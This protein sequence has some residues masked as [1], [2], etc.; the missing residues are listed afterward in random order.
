M[1][2]MLA[3]AT[4]GAVAVFMSGCEWSG[5]GSDDGWSS[6]GISS[7]VSGVY[8]AA[9]GS[10][11][12]KKSAPSGPAG[13]E[14]ASESLGT[15]NGVNATFTKTLDNAPVTRGSV[16]VSDGIESF[17]DP[18]GDGS[19]T[20]TSGGNGTINYSSGQI[21]VNFFVSPGNG[22]SV[23]VTYSFPISGT[24]DNPAAG[25]SKNILSFN[26]QQMGNKVRIQ[27]N[28]GDSYEGALG[29]AQTASKGSVQN[30]SDTTAEQNI[31]EVLQFSAEGSSGGKHTRMTGVFQVNQVVYFS[32]SFTDNGTGITS[33]MTEL[34]RI[35][36]YTIDGTWME[37]GGTTGS[38]G[39][40]GP[41][42]Q[43]I[44]IITD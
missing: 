23:L 36:S 34:Y 41:A 3:M 19:L 35:A 38:I 5:S 28:N 16:Q 2:R 26:V 4:V 33:T 29:S 32:R 10:F 6:S 43:R 18:E 14:N 42:N 8:K 30:T 7:D 13:V 21:T 25:S 12:V 11:L 15:G 31:A 1:K 17:T 37:D 24:D 40:V 39:G 22:K 9:D 44:Q 20:G 27:D